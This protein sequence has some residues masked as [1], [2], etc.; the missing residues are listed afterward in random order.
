MAWLMSLLTLARAED[1]VL[2]NPS[3]DTLNVAISGLTSTEP[4]PMMSMVLASQQP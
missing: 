3:A 1:D 2:P 4:D